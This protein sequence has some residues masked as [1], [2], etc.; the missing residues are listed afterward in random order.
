[1]QPKTLQITSVFAAF[2]ISI[3]ASPT[4]NENSAVGLMVFQ[5]G[6]LTDFQPISGFGGSLHVLWTKGLRRKRWLFALLGHWM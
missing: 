2:V 6:H 1:M 5:S 3:F 4:V